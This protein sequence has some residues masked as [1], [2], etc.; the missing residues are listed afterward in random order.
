M[1]LISEYEYKADTNLVVIRLTERFE[2]GSD[3]NCKIA[4]ELFHAICSKGFN[5]YVKPYRIGGWVPSRRNPMDV[6]WTRHLVGKDPT[7]VGGPTITLKQPRVTQNNEE[8]K[9][10][11]RRYEINGKEVIIRTWD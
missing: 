5:L 10:E 9:G 8:P 6:S 3:T 11:T 2:D 1:G 7:I 4:A